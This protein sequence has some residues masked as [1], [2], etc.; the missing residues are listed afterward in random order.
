MMLDGAEA[1]A[2]VELTPGAAARPHVALNMVETPAQAFGRCNVLLRS[3][4][5][6]ARGGR[7]EVTGLP[8]REAAL[9]RCEAAVRGL[10]L[11]AA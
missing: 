6:L 2:H 4:L 8:D 3:L 7:C 9:A 10:V 11:A 1:A 5:I